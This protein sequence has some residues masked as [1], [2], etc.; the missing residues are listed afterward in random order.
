[1]DEF[2]NKHHRMIRYV[3]YSV[4]FLV[5][6]VILF[7]F[8]QTSAVWKKIW[9]EVFSSL[10]PFFVAFLLA[11][12]IHPLIL[13]IERLRLPR[14][15]SVT[16]FYGGV[17][18]GLYGGISWFLP[19]LIREVHDLILNLPTY[20]TAIQNQLLLFDHEMGL[21]LSEFFFSQY[22]S[23]MGAISEHIQEVSSFTFNLIFSIIGSLMFIVI[24]PIALFYF[25]KD[26]EKIVKGLVGVFPS[27]YR[28]HV[29]RISQLLDRSLGE[30][31][32]GVFLVMVCVSLIATVLLMFAGIDYAL[33][34]GFLIGLTDF[35]PFIGPFIGAIPVIIFAL[36]ISWNKVIVVIIILGILQAIE[37]NFL[38]P[39]IIGRNL[40]MHPLFIMI[41]MMLAGSFFGLMGIFFAIPVFL[42]GRTLVTYA[43]Q[44]KRGTK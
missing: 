15:I 38:Q 34:F 23:W 26:Y 30:Y 37:G 31:I 6:L 33:L 3:L 1:M 25:L 22:P 44:I 17:F 32:R 29:V 42:V 24:V 19:T 28:P 7:L 12:L 8:I 35:I 11:Y 18:G 40:D 27:Q 2:F 13:W 20:L 5:S 39:F 41:L 36:S 43:I 21:H 9:G 14:V 10:F 16:L 4:A